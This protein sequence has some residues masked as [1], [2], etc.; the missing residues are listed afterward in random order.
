MSE[1]NGI[2]A[3]MPEVEITIGGKPY[4]VKLTL[5]AF[6]LIEQATGKSALSGDLL[7]N[8]VSTTTLIAWAGAR[9]FA[10][11]L[12]LKEVREKMKIKELGLNYPILM[13]ALAAAFNSDGEKKSEENEAG[14]QKE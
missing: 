13:K 3:L 1:D 8:D 9:E 7:K 4:K 11:E 10:P 5:E 12:T 14:E 2:S 6:C